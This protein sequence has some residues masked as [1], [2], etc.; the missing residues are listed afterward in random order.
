MFSR[1][2]RNAILSH[3]D[4]NFFLIGRFFSTASRHHPLEPLSGGIMILWFY[5]KQ[6]GRYTWYRYLLLL[7]QSC[8]FLW[9]AFAI[10]KKISNSYSNYRSFWNLLFERSWSE[11]G[12][13]SKDLHDIHEKDINTFIK[14]C[15]KIYMIQKFAVLYQSCCFLCYAFAIHE[16]KIS[17][18]DTQKL[19]PKKLVGEES[20]ETHC[21]KLL[22][23]CS[24]FACNAW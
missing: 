12:V 1:R 3:P 21:K 11:I 15:I 5:S 23:S 13:V 8:S 2:Q 14:T 9:Y 6:V 4:W 17:V 10:H 20:F 18:L 19:Y 22:V 16:K 7:Y 24:V